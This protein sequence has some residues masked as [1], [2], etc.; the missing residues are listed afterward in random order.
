M[1]AGVAT[2]ATGQPLAIA[3]AFFA[4]AALLMAFAWVVLRDRERRIE[5]TGHP[6]INREIQH[7]YPA[8]VA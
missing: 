2:L 1:I 5:Q 7:G 3:I 8:D 6:G 4:I